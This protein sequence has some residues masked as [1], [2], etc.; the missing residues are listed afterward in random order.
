MKFFFR[1]IIFTE[2]REKYSSNFSIREFGPI[3]Y[4]KIRFHACADI[5][6]VTIEF[7]TQNH[8]H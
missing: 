1:L 7:I 6:V 4:F 3:F 8:T 2:L 5:F